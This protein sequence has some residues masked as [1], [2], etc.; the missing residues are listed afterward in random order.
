VF[1]K[2]GKITMMFPERFKETVDFSKKP[3]SGEIPLLDCSGCR[4]GPGACAITG[5]TIETDN[6]IGEFLDVTATMRFTT[7]DGVIFENLAALE[8]VANP[9][10]WYMDDVEAKRYFDEN[11]NFMPE[12]V[13]EELGGPESLAL[14]QAAFTKFTDPTCLMRQKR[15]PKIVGASPNL[16][17]LLG[18]AAESHETYLENIIRYLTTELDLYTSITT[19]DI[20]AISGIDQEAL[21]PLLENMAKVGKLDEPYTNTDNG[22][23]YWDLPQSRF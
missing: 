19:S 18:E 23:T 16:R 6:D 4:V 11:G 7:P 17:S 22:H 13:W 1:N 5:L 3:F 10:D 20:A 2:K 15:K 9:T 8:G 12:T 14:E 21:T